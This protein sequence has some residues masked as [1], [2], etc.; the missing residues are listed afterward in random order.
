MEN[1]ECLESRPAQQALGQGQD[2]RNEEKQVAAIVGE[3][4]H[5]VIYVQPAYQKIG[6]L[7][8]T[9]VIMTM[10]T[11][12]STLVRTSSKGFDDRCHRRGIHS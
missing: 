2:G 12:K 7:C 5:E 11:N 9:H 6:M 4:L 3:D 8:R 10:C 1:G